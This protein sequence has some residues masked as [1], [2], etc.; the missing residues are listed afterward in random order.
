MKCFIKTVNIL[1]F[2]FYLI[3]EIK[4]RSIITEEQLASF[5]YGDD[6]FTLLVVGDT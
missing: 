1:Y 3:I 4:A 2:L 6:E 5:K